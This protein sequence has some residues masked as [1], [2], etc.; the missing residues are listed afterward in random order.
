MPQMAAH[1]AAW[2][3]RW[4]ASGVAPTAATGGDVAGFTVTYDDVAGRVVLSVTGAAGATTAHFQRSTDLVTWTDVR[5]GQ[6][7]PVASGLAHLFDYE[8]AAGVTNNYRVIFDAGSTVRATVTPVQTQVWLKNPVRP[9]LNR[10]VSIVDFGDIT[11]NSRSGVFDV[12]GRTNQVAVTDL[13]SGRSTT[14]TI[15]TTTAGEANAVDEMLAVGE[16]LFLQPVYQSALPTMYAVPGSIDRSRVAQ[17]SAVRRFALP[18]TEVAIPDLTLAAVQSTWQTVIN[19]YATWAD[20]IAAKA[21]WYDV[22][23][24]VGTAADVVTS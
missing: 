15:R 5:G 17:S 19:T 9:F 20:L 7:S 21:T 4:P 13:M 11:R 2:G 23:Q 12:I 10:V 8:Y 6:A 3:K 22:L 18:L 14:V 1:I 24:I 16:V